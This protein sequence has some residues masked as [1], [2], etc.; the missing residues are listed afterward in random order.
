M[1]RLLFIMFL[2]L[3]SFVFASAYGYFVPNVFFGASGYNSISVLQEDQIKEVEVNLGTS[4]GASMI[5]EYGLEIG[6]RIGVVLSFDNLALKTQNDT[7]YS[8]ILG[9]GISTSFV[10]P[11]PQVESIVRISAGL[12]FVLLGP[13]TNLSAVDLEGEGSFEGKVYFTD[14]EFF[15]ALTEQFSIGAGIGIRFYDLYIKDQDLV[16]KSMPV[17]IKIVFS[18]RF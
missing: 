15:K 18:Y 3:A 7:L 1:K 17:P 9:A 13:A 10:F 16:V 6:L 8:T 4:Y 12:N 2:S 14:V 5:F 11:F